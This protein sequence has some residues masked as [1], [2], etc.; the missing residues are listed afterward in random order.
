MRFLSS[1]LPLRQ[2]SHGRARGRV[3]RGRRDQGRKSKSP[4]VVTQQNRTRPTL[5]RVP[6]HAS[7][8]FPQF[9]VGCD[10]GRY[11]PFT[12]GERKGQTDL[13]WQKEEAHVIDI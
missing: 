11:R 12:N 5:A 10:L 9:V 3:P 2:D 13:Q 4:F 7:H 6:S 8:R 1:L